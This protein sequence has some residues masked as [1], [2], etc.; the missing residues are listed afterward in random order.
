MRTVPPFLSLSSGWALM[1]SCLVADASCCLVGL[2]LEALPPPPDEPPHAATTIAI[3]ATRTAQ[4][5]PL[6]KRTITS[7]LLTAFVVCT[8]SLDLRR[9]SPPRRSD[10][11]R[12]GRPRGRTAAGPPPSPPRPPPPPG[13]G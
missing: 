8:F 3:A 1:S 7:R 5:G 11:R 6:L 13:G 4:M 12:S 9:P 2:A 10:T